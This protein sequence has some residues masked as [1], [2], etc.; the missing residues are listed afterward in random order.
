MSI[1]DHAVLILVCVLSVEI[2]V[3]SN[4]LKALGAILDVTGKAAFVMSRK[5]VSDHWKAKVVPEYALRL[6]K[7]STR[8]SLVVL[9]VLFLFVTADFLLGN[10]RALALSLIGAI[11]T[12]L[13]ATGYYYLRKSYSQ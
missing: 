4:L 11:E 2:V 1:V 6:L 8:V 9:M 3:R 5:S 12:V 13:F 7:L 10:F